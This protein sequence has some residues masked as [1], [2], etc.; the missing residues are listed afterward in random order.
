MKRAAN[1]ND[2]YFNTGPSP[3]NYKYGLGGDTDGG[4]E[5]MESLLFQREQ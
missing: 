4:L 3:P 1:N 5:G 2:R